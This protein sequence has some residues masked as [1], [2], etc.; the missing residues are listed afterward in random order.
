MNT[1]GIEEILKERAQERSLSTKDGV[2]VE[3][4][5]RVVDYDRKHGEVI[6]EYDGSCGVNYGT[7]ERPDHWFRVRRDDGTENSFNAERLY[8]EQN[9]RKGM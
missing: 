4:G 1:P 2:K 7:D 6:A 3:L 8:S 9:Y 5:L